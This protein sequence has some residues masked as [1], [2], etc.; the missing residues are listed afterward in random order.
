MA[1]VEQ[2]LLDDRI[3]AAKSAV[4]ACLSTFRFSLAICGGVKRAGRGKER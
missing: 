1:R 4:S 3:S 2:R